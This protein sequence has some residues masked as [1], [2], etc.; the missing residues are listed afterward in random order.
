MI[1]NIIIIL[2]LKILINIINIKQKL[3]NKYINILNKK[4]ISFYINS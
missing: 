1:L 3:V 4:Y 2:L